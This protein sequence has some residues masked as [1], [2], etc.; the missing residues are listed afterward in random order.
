MN[1]AEI[2]AALIDE[3][4]RIAPE[5]DPATLDPGEDLREQIDLDSMDVLNFITAV[6]QRLS[7]DIPDA[8]AARFVTLDGA[9]AYLLEKLSDG[10]A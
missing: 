9:T 1:D 5:I 7:V 6:H 4:T 8:E 10:A 3:L 2:R